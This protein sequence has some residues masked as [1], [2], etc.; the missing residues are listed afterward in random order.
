MQYIE[1]QVPDTHQLQAAE[2]VKRAR[3]MKQ[4]NPQAGWYGECAGFPLLH[5]WTTIVSG[6]FTKGIQVHSN[7]PAKMIE[8]ERQALAEGAR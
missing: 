7:P 5:V 1:E 2:A 3:M 6:G 4:H 8:F